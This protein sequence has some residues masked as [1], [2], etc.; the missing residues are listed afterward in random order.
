VAAAIDTGAGMP[1]AGHFASALDGNP[2][3]DAWMSASNLSGLAAARMAQAGVAR[4]TGTAATALGSLLGSF[5]P[6]P[7][8][9]ELGVRWDVQLGYFK[10]HAACSFT[11][12]VADALL[13]LRPQLPADSTGIEE[14][15]VETHSLGSGLTRTTWDSRLAA[16]FSTPFVAAAVVLHGSMGPEASSAE[17]R[18]DPRVSE[19]A[20]RVRLVTAPD[21]DARLPDERAARV[22]VRTAGG[23]FTAEVPNPIGDAANQPFD[24]DDVLGLLTGLL[25]D[26]HAVT[27]IRDV[28]GALPGA[29]DVAPL[30]SRLAL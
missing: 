27:T 14:I 29:D 22:T 28:L 25:G 8:T 30:L 2:V 23:A 10:R 16:L 19:L 20:R 13:E 15:L 5:D 1:I 3:R 7:L 18:A 17:M 24:E 12:P 4:N 6:T 21:L 11:H 26:Q 9:D